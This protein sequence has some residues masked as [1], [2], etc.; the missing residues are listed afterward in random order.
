[1]F[2]Q[3]STHS[4]HAVTKTV[5]KKKIV[6]TP[7][8]QIAKCRHCNR[9]MLVKNCYLDTT[10]SPSL[11]KDGKQYSVTVFDQHFYIYKW[12]HLLLQG[13]YWSPRN[14]TPS[15]G[16]SWFSNFPQQEACCKSETSPIWKWRK[17]YWITFVDL[18]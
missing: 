4:W 18:F 3:L 11:E 16:R 15:T 2:H 6:T 1:M 13:Q 14:Q 7:G 8:S 17:C 10:V 12:R 9:S 5:H